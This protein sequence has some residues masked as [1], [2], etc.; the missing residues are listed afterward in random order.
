M[1]C[2]QATIDG[3]HLDDATLA[4]CC[5]QSAVPF[6][7]D[8]NSYVLF[9]LHWNWLPMLLPYAVNKKAKNCYNE[10]IN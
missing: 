1:Y 10:G 7:V 3:Y 2:R 6:S 5:E 4:P 9:S 8:N